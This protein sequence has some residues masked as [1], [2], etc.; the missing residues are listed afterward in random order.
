MTAFLA[1]LLSS[2]RYVDLYELPNP[3]DDVFVLLSHIAKK[4]NLILKI[5]SPSGKE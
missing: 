3:V 5:K 1:N 2:L 4:L